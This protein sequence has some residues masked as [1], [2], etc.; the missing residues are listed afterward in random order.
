M[1][2]N[3]DPKETELFA[4]LTELLAENEIEQNALRVKVGS[5]G[6]EL[7]RAY[8]RLF[9]FGL[10]S[11][12][13]VRPSVL[14]RLFGGHEAVFIGLTDEGRQ[15]A[16]KM[17]VDAEVVAV[18]SETVDQTV[19]EQKARQQEDKLYVHGGAPA[20]PSHDASVN[21]ASRRSAVAQSTSRLRLSD[22]TE[23]LGGA[24]VEQGI[25]IPASNRLDGLAELVGLLGFD[26]TRAG[27]LL[28]ANRWAEG[29]S[30]TEVALEIVVASLA[31]AARLKLTKTTDLEIDAVVH[32]IEAVRETFRPFV[33]E[34][35]LG[36]Q[37]LTEALTM[38]R[39]FF[40]GAVGM[41]EFDQY[42]AD[43][44]RG[45]APPATC[46]EHIFLLVNVEE[47]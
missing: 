10:V 6:A 23:T 26:L 28:A 30:D 7:G 37:V 3:L 16:I 45:L 43:P 15:L 31:H 8:L 4:I 39:G 27:R 1:A 9:D 5:Q 21:T 38:M 20:V 22:Y 25:T 13:L 12:R 17:F 41:S 19:L 11:E 46:P 44:L 47:D 32:L 29:Q 36:E 18:E 2:R 33:R 40:V 35:M 14:R 24:P 42:L 34:S